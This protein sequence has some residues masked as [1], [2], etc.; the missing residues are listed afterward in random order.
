MMSTEASSVSRRPVASRASQAARSALVATETKFAGAPL[1]RVSVDGAFEGYASLFDVVDLG[2]DQVVAGAFRECLQ[3]KPLRNVKLLW[4][5]E[6]S[7]PLGVWHDIQEDEK[8]LHV[9]GQL[10]LSVA[11]A[12]EIHSL[13]RKG[14]VDGLSIGFRTERSRKD[15]ST[16]VRRLEKLD[17]WEI[18][19]V[20]FPM[21][22]G[23][24]ISSVKQVARRALKLPSANAELASSIRRS[25]A[26]LLPLP[27][28]PRRRAGKAN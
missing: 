5:H 7:Q 25:A 16:G 8:G 17:L 15:A 3:R 1:A 11:K 2:R 28:H 22:P 14:A 24:R 19:I 18:S 10:D 9:R 6:P 21:L 20:T 27:G 23:A 26:R 13:M 12:R 4:Q